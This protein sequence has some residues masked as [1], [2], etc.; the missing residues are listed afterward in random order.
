MGGHSIIVSAD[1]SIGKPN[2]CMIVKR[3]FL[4]TYSDILGKDHYRFVAQDK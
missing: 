2:L 3:V 4:V 1:N